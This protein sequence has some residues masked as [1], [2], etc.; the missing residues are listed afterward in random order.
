MV[1]LLTICLHL[2]RL[3]CYIDTIAVTYVSLEYIGTI[4]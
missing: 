4:S 3:Y 1:M 2:L